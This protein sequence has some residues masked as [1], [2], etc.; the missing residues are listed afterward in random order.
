[1]AFHDRPDETTRFKLLEAI[2]D[3]IELTFADAKKMLAIERWVRA[4]DKQE[5]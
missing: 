2:D 4:A 1:L 3:S 5:E